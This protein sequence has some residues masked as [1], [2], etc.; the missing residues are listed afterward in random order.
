LVLCTR[1]FSSF[2]IDRKAGNFKQKWRVKTKKS[3]RVINKTTFFNMDLVVLWKF[4]NKTILIY[5]G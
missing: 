5:V 2:L 1:L 4:M 3:H